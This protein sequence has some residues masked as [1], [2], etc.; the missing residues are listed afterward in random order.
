M[1]LARFLCVIVV[2]SAA[3]PPLA[4][5]D[6][7]SFFSQDAPSASSDKTATP[8]Q[9]PQNQGAAAE[10]NSTAP[11]NPT[12]PSPDAAKPP[13][14]P[15]AQA[16][17]PVP[18]RRRK[19]KAVQANCNPAPPADP[20]SAAG[21]SSAPTSSSPTDTGAAGSPATSAANAPTNCPPTK[22]I[23]RR[24]GTTEQS[25]QLGGAAG[26]SQAWHERDTNQMLVST[27]QNLKRIDGTKLTADQQDVVTHIRQFMEQSKSATAAGDSERARTLAWKAHL[28]SE[29]LV[30]QQ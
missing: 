23:V 5:A 28:L 14:V 10:Q 3:A 13:A 29:G 11:S 30:K 2:C 9:P 1:T 21:S 25:I 20:S 12:T 15:N 17:P 8:A 4:V 27:Q 6:V 24:G 7:R 18:H 19:K 16:T 22:V 26:G